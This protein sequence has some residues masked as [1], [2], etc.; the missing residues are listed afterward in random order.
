MATSLITLSI[1]LGSVSA[2]WITGHLL[3]AIKLHPEKRKP[4]VYGTNKSN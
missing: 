3:M 1:S 2:L 4:K